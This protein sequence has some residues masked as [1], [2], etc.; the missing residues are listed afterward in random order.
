MSKIDVVC[1]DRDH[2]IHHSQTFTDDAWTPLRCKEHKP[3]PTNSKTSV[4]FN[5]DSTRAPLHVL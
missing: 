1:F 4:N 2:A 3:W 5:S